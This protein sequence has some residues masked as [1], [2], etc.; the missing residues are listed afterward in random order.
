MAVDVNDDEY[1]IDNA[2]ATVAN[3]DN[4]DNKA[5]NDKDGDDVHLMVKLV[6]SAY[7]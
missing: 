2:D 3:T 1:N 5:D 6:D 7:S 4:E